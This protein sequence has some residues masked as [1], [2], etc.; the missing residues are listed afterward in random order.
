MKPKPKAKKRTGPGNGLEIQMYLHCRRC[1]QELAERCE[2]TG[3]PQSPRD[4]AR[5][6]VGWTPDG[7]QVWCNR[8]ECNVLHVDFEGRKHPANLTAIAN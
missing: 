5:L 8:H 1:V 2:R 3:E 4:Y 7:L 6:A